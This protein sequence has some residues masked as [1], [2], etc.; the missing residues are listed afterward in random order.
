MERNT[1]IPSS[2]APAEFEVK[3]RR[4]S[5]VHPI[6]LIMLALVLLLFVVT[7]VKRY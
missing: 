2:L 1:T 3:P 5:G 6:F 7:L 4:R